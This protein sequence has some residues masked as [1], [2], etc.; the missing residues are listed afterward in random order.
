MKTIF[1]TLADTYRLNNNLVKPAR[2]NHIYKFKISVDFSADVDEA[3]TK[4]GS[5]GFRSSQGESDAYKSLSLTYNPNIAVDQHKSTLGTEKLTVQEQYYADKQKFDK[6]QGGANSYYDSYG[7]NQRTDASKIGKLG[8]FL[9]SCNRTMI[10]SRISTIP[11]K[12]VET[13]AFSYMWHRDEPVFE[14][15]RFNIPVTSDSNYLFQL[16][17]KFMKPF[18]QSPFMVTEHL[19]LGYGYSWDTNKPHRVFADNLSDIE[20]TNI[21][22]GFSPWFDFVD[23]GW[24]PNEFFGK[25]HPLDMLVDGDVIPTKYIEFVE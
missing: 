17:T 9:D 2:T 25:K 15:L 14:N 8:E 11:A 19:D 21:V 22:L 18:P 13:T 16:E 7:F 10:R 4:Y 24:I 3:F 20:R 1:N 23:D 5:Y 12:R 6:L